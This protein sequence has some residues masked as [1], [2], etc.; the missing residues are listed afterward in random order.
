MSKTNGPSGATPA[1]QDGKIRLGPLDNFI[2]FNLRLAQDA[3]F[4]T[5]AQRVG[6]PHLRPG[7]F[8]AMMLIHQNPGITQMELSRAIARDKSSVTPLVQTLQREGLIT[9]TPSETDRRRVHMRLTEAGEKALESL[10]AHAEEHDRKLDAI[11]G[12]RKAE[13]LELLK[14]ITRQLA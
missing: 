14:M 12:D 3:S 10:L 2:G 9:R 11:V 6:K 8:A 5:Y 1:E 7:R 13:L 4:Q